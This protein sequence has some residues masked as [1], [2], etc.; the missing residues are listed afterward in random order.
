MLADLLQVVRQ[1]VQASLGLSQLL[2]A[3]LGRAESFV[4]ARNG[5]RVVVERGLRVELGTLVLDSL[6]ID[7][8]LVHDV[9]RH[10]GVDDL[11]SSRLVFLSKLAFQ[12]ICWL[13]LFLNEATDRLEILLQL[14]QPRHLCI[15]HGDLVL[16]LVA[17][18]LVVCRLSRIYEKILE[19]HHRDYLGGYSRF[20]LLHL[21]FEHI[22][23]GLRLSSLLCRTC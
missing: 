17:E 6:V 5:G 8:Y 4:S 1:I 7:V 22:A 3:A 19:S 10:H 13:A 12:I 18:V 11:R 2:T 21:C 23:S 9:A 20:H 15:Y 14:L 16:E